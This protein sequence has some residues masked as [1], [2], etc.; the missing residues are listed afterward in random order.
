MIFLPALVS[1]AIVNRP[2]TQYAFI[3]EIR[4]YAAIK[5]LDEVVLNRLIKKI[6]IGEVQKVDGQKI[7][8][9]KIIYNFVG[10]ISA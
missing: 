7:Q 9:V 4:K 3:E 8:E 1:Y 2:P 6:M 5:E 10:E